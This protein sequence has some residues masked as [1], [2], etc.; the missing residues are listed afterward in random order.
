VVNNHQDLQQAEEQETSYLL[1]KLDQSVNQCLSFLKQ[2]KTAIIAF[3]L[4][5]NGE[6]LAN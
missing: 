6:F 2:G 1:A 4:A 3:L 5:K